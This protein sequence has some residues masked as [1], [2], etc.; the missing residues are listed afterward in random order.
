MQ[1]RQDFP[2]K[3]GGS[4]M[5]GIMHGRMD[6][7]VDEWRDR[8][9]D[10]QLVVLDVELSMRLPARLAVRDANGREEMEDRS[11][12]PPAERVA[13]GCPPKGGVHAGRAP[14]GLNGMIRDRSASDSTPAGE[15]F[16]GPRDAELSH[17]VQRSIMTPHR[18]TSMRSTRHRPPF[19]KGGRTAARHLARALGFPDGVRAHHRTPDRLSLFG[20]TAV[21]RGF[22]T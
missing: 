19:R 8:L 12:T 11:E 6:G 15:A 17:Q 22:M 9:F 7:L 2:P 18:V 1:G 16:A 14:P 21:G 10:V 13:S 3:R 5:D 4:N 20:S